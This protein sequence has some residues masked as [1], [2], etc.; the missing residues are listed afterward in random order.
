MTFD[1]SID[2]RVAHG[3]AFAPRPKPHDAY[4]H[5]MHLAYGN[6]YDPH[7]AVCRCGYIGRPRM[8]RMQAEAD[9]D[10]HNKGAA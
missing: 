10:E 7:A 4:P 1:P 8:N 9:A 5:P 2:E 6:H 3:A